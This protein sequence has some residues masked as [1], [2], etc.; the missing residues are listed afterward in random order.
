MIKKDCWLCGKTF[1]T[2]DCINDSAC[3]ECNKKI[4]EK[5]LENNK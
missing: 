2:P 4:E 3:E 1:T 5:E